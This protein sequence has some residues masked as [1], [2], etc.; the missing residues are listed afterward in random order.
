MRRQLSFPKWEYRFFISL[1]LQFSICS[2]FSQWTWQNPLPQGNS[3]TSVYFTDSM[4]GYCAGTFG[5]LLKS[6]DGG[7]TWIVLKTNTTEN[8]CGI[9]FINSDKD[10]G[11]IV[12]SHG[13]IS[14]C[15]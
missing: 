13:L 4:T 5:T 6:T 12:G 2:V 9:R 10:K 15:L 14:V 7:N 11:F 3:L 1:V 8:L